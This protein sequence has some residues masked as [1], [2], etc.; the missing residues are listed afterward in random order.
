MI[1]REDL[2]A[3]LTELAFDA[4]V[5]A[6]VDG[7]YREDASKHLGECEEVRYIR[8]WQRG[9]DYGL[10]CTLAVEVPF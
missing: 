8:A 9:W 3:S 5:D 2:I 6:F 7:E 4:G 10:Q 1:A